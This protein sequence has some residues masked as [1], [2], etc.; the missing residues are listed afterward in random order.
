[1]ASTSAG[2]WPRKSWRRQSIR[3]A[4][5]RSSGRIF[6]RWA[7]CSGNW[8]EDAPS[9]VNGIYASTLVET[10]RFKSKIHKAERKQFIYPNTFLNGQTCF[11]HRGKQLA[12]FSQVFMKI[13]SCLITTWCLLTRLSRT[14]GRWCVSRSSDPTFPT[15][16][17]AA[18]W[19]G[20]THLLRPDVI[21]KFIKYT[22]IY[23]DPD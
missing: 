16:G 5:N 13:F 9:G 17:R 14:W 22:C 10:I 12:S 11:A 1:M 8:P 6:T 19:D 4:L 2:T 3:E 15:S 18:R 21:T 20:R 7:W 23:K